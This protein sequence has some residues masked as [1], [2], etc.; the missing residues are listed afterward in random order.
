MNAFVLAAYAV[1][2]LATA[3]LLLW[4]HSTMRTAERAAD[5]LKRPERS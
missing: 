1:M 4:A 5:T 2:V 3:S